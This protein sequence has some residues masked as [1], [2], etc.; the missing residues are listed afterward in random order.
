MQMI[1]NVNQLHKMSSVLIAGA[2]GALA[3]AD[4]VLPQLQAVLP[5]WVYAVLCAAII[6]ARAIK[7]PK[8]GTS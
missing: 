7:Q 4:S 1:D 6:V 8:L 5:P 2:T 3:I